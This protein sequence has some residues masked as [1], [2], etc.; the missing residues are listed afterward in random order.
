MAVDIN[1]GLVSTKPKVVFIGDTS[2]GS[3][4]FGCQ[5]VGQTFREQFSRAGVELI[6]SLP[7]DFHN[8]HGF[9]E[10]L[11]NADLLVI[12][13]EGSIHH[14][15]F[16]YL[17]KLASEYPSALVNC[18]YQENPV[19]PELKDFLYISTRE[20]YSANEIISQGV[21]CHVVPDVLFA[22]SLLNSFVYHEP[23][24][25]FG[26]TDNAQKTTYKF[27]PFRLRLRLGR[28]PKQKMVADYLNFL[29]QH[30]RMCIGRFHAAIAASVLG[31]PF[32]TWDSNTWK[33]RGLM[34]DMGLSHLHFTNREE[35]MKAIPLEYDPAISEFV[36]R[37]KENI[38]TMFDTL[39]RIANA[40]MDQVHPGEL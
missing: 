28:S 4:H 15:R 32:S 36:E 25:D 21:E 26:V 20:S 12:N 27:G 16:H 3:P 7:Y 40:R 9:T 8:Y 24:K 23:I 29:C 10:I 14:G 31:I 22:S 38:E 30:K 34:H 17:I 39:A 13:G 35:A 2:L 1:N 19:W 33:M 18:V 11:E 5:L 37:A 6:A